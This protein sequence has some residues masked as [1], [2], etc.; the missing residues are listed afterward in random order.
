MYIELINARPDGVVVKRPYGPGMTIDVFV[1]PV[2]LRFR[3]T[4]TGGMEDAPGIVE[5][6]EKVIGGAPTKLMVPV[7]MTF[8]QDDTVS[9]VRVKFHK[10]IDRKDTVLQR[11]TYDNT[12]KDL[13]IVMDVGYGLTRT[14]VRFVK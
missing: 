13:D 1:S 4:T 6:F 14:R 10:Q 7:K 5:I 2:H 8:E 3:R 11:F 9:R 12:P